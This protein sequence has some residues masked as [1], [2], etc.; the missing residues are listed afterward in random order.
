MLVVCPFG[1]KGLPFVFKF[2]QKIRSSGCLATWSDVALFFFLIF[3][4]KI[5]F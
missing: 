2:G 5:D 1:H 3:E 4:S